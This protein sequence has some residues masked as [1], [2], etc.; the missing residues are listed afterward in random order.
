MGGVLVGNI[1]YGNYLLTFYFSTLILYSIIGLIVDSSKREK[2]EST[3]EV[4]KNEAIRTPLVRKILQVLITLSVLFAIAYLAYRYKIKPIID[5]YKIAS[6]MFFITISLYSLLVLIKFV[7]IK[8]LD[9][10]FTPIRKS[11][12]K[13]LGFVMLLVC[14]AVFSSTNQINSFLLDKKPIITDLLIMTLLTLWYFAVVFFSLSYMILALEGIHSF[15]KNL[16]KGKRF[17]IN[18]K[19]KTTRNWPYFSE[20]LN[21]KLDGIERGQILK[22][23]G[24][25]L[26]WVLSVIVEAIALIF[27]YL[28]IRTGELLIFL[29]IKLFKKCYKWLDDIIKNLGKSIIIVF[30]GSLVCTLIF[31]FFIDKYQQILTTAGSE[32]YEFMCGVIIIPLIITQILE[33]KGK[34]PNTKLEP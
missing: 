31:I 18:F 30:R 32:I 5:I 6:Y 29:G 2:D 21:R 14:A 3:K 22:K 8:P 28:F 25:Y 15:C 9:F 20:E 19:K 10:K 27:E 23:F 1:L 34:Q 26:I 13:L 24:Y 17:K 11:A 33:I 12:L 16:N 7:Y 4:D